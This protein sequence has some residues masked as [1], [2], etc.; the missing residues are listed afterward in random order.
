MGEAE[1]N[2][3]HATSK[4]YCLMDACPELGGISVWTLRKHIAQGTVS[5]I[6]LGR[7]IFLSGQEIARIKREGL[8][9][10]KSR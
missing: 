6:K 9:S 10:L 5:V 8:P 4:L 2:H 3:E 1:M 7:R